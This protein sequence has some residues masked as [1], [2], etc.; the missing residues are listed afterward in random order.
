MYSFH[1]KEDFETLS[2]SFDRLS[3]EA[4][5]A[6]KRWPEP[7]DKPYQED[8]DQDGD[9]SEASDESFE[10]DETITKLP[11]STVHFASTS[12]HCRRGDSHRFLSEGSSVLQEL[13]VEFRPWLQHAGNASGTSASKSTSIADSPNT[14]STGTYPRVRAEAGPQRGKRSSNANADEDE[15]EDEP[16]QG[17]SKKR[18]RKNRSSGYIHR[19]LACPFA[20]KDPAK[21][22][23]CNK[24]RITRIQDVKQHLRRFHE[25]PIYC[26]ICKD[27]FKSESD[28]QTHAE[29]KSCTLRPGKVDGVDRDQKKKLLNNVPRNLSIEDQWFFIF[30]ILFPGF[31]PRPRS[32]YVE[33]PAN[34]V[35]LAFQH[36]MVHQGL[37]LLVARLQARGIVTS[38]LGNSGQLLLATLAEG[39]EAIVDEWN[40]SLRADNVAQV[41]N[42]S[43]TS[44]GLLQSG[45]ASSISSPLINNS[46]EG[47]SLSSHA[48]PLQTALSSVVDMP[49]GF[50]E[51]GP[52]SHSSNDGE[53][54]RGNVR[55][56]TR[57]FKRARY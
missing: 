17:G 52:R 20:K 48:S 4:W 33:G 42:S 28:L 34:P 23:E 49:I 14:A 43:G 24:N 2:L 31:D 41:P 35:L 36:F 46:R 19:S 11:S 12:K 16:G 1:D 39:Q 18:S 53:T 3:L 44:P 50:A 54:P 26:L 55:T 56:C 32:P 57:T 30:D 25:P 6:A 22:H 7:A 29:A 37:T 21:Y 13:V 51:V 27:T 9:E 10:W 15:D 45:L 40:S 5:A 8:S 38:S 47:V